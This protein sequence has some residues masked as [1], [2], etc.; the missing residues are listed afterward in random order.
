M[1]QRLGATSGRLVSGTL[2][3]TSSLCYEDG[4]EGGG[5]GWKGSLWGL[6]V[7]IKSE[8]W[9]GEKVRVDTWSGVFDSVWA[10]SGL[11]Q[12]LEGSRGCGQLNWRRMEGHWNSEVTIIWGQV[13]TGTW[14]RPEV[15]QSTRARGEEEE[16][17]PAARVWQVKGGV[18]RVLGSMRGE[19]SLSFQEEGILYLEVSLM[20]KEKCHPTIWLWNSM[21]Q[22]WL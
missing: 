4:S 11:W 10:N 20:N 2:F 19:G 9:E 16:Q 8:E 7:F 13:L 18:W 14:H 12:N 1:W 15:I 3:L 21:T 6:R 22:G 17:E 5:L